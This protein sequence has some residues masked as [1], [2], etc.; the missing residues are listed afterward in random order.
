[1]SLTSAIIIITLIAFTTHHHRLILSLVT[2]TE[3]STLTSPHFGWKPPRLIVDNRC[4]RDW[5]TTRVWSRPTTI[6]RFDRAWDDSSHRDP[7]IYHINS[8]EICNLL[9]VENLLANNTYNLGK[10]MKFLE[11]AKSWLL[12]CEK[13]NIYPRYFILPSFHFSSYQVVKGISIKIKFKLYYII[14]N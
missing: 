6:S 8:C 11:I 5:E 2:N 9:V 10:L 3:R 13:F 12:Q 14:I 4:T 1:M 7:W